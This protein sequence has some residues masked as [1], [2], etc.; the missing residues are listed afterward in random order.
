M[1]RSGS[2]K[3]LEYS[4]LALP[5]LRSLATKINTLLRLHLESM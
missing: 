3:I 5:S 2:L 1:R 4:S